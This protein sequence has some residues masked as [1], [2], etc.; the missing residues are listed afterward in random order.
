MLKSE[1][2]KLGH[3]LGLTLLFSLH[4]SIPLY[5]SLSFDPFRCFQFYNFIHSPMQY[6]F[7]NLS[8]SPLVCPAAAS[9][10][11]IPFDFYINGIHIHWLCNWTILVFTDG[12]IESSLLA[13]VPFY[14]L[15]I[16]CVSIRFTFNLLFFLPLNSRFIAFFLYRFTFLCVAL[17]ALS[18]NLVL[19]FSFTSSLLFAIHFVQTIILYSTPFYSI[20]DAPLRWCFSLFFFPFHS[21]YLHRL[22]LHCKNEKRNQWESIRCLVASTRQLG[23]NLYARF[24]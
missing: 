18:L 13:F 6:L 7:F 15:S 12:H 2:L 11:Y 9:H 14:S 3:F 5:L 22:S 23:K 21:P 16:F 19:F 24:L 4:L 20:F 10:P 1:R 8:S 17:C